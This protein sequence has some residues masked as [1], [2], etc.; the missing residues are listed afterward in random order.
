MI[1]TPKG[2]YREGDS[3]TFVKSLEDLGL[4]ALAHNN[5]YR[6][7]HYVT[8]IQ[9][10]KKVKSF[11]EIQV[12]TIYEEAWSE[13]DHTVNYPKS[14]VPIVLLKFLQVLNRLSGSADEMGTV[15]KELFLLSEKEKSERQNLQKEKDDAFL[16]LEQKINELVKTKDENEVLQSELSSLKEKQKGKFTYFQ[17]IDDDI[18]NKFLSMDHEKNSG[19]IQPFKSGK[20]SRIFLDTN[21]GSGSIKLNNSENNQV[22]ERG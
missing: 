6:S 18:L 13:I 14:D 11:V 9:I 4:E 12:R 5:G 16:R 1:E 10:N 17:S 19:F 15:I 8:N 7:I 2:Y 20:P 22:E 21:S 3:E